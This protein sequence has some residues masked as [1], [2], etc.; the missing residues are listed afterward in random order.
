MNPAVSFLMYT[1]KHLSFM[2][3]ILYSIVQTIGAFVGSGL[4]Y[5]V[6]YGDTFPLQ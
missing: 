5:Y 4:A 1:R 6:Y 2:D 3:F